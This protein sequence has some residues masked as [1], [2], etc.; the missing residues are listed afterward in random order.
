MEFVWQLF[1]VIKNLRDK[2]VMLIAISVE[3]NHWNLSIKVICCYYKAH[4]LAW[5]CMEL[6][7]LVW[8]TFQWPFTRATLLIPF[9]ESSR[10]GYHVGSFLLQRRDSKYWHYLRKFSGHIHIITPLYYVPKITRLSKKGNTPTMYFKSNSQYGIGNLYR[11]DTL[12]VAS[13]KI[14]LIK[15]LTFGDSRL[16]M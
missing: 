7:L 9:L 11:V 12:N 4:N 6:K 2:A 15:L 8:R 3:H 10:K 1:C 14:Y 13:D 5:S 16:L